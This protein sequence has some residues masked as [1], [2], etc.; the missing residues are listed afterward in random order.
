MLDKWCM[1]VTERGYVMLLTLT[2]LCSKFHYFMFPK[3]I[4]LVILYARE[5]IASTN[6]DSF[7]REKHFMVL[8]LLA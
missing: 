4:I 8:K 5:F 6:T 1:C 7:K 3:V 2:Y